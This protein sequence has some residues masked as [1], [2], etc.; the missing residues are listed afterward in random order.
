LCKEAGIQPGLTKAQSQSALSRPRSK[1][2]TLKDVER[3]RNEPVPKEQIDA[4]K[5]QLSTTKMKASLTK[6]KYI[7]MSKKNVEEIKRIK[8][9]IHEL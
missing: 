3:E 7:V 5:R 4:A 1:L 6:N 2:R 8:H 9:S